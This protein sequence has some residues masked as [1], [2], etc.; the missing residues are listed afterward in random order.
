MGERRADLFVGEEAA[1]VDQ[2][3]GSES[4]ALGARRRLLDA[5]AVDHD[6]TR[7]IG[8]WVRG[9]GHGRVGEGV[10]EW[11]GVRGCQWAWLMARRG[12]AR[13]ARP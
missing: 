6:L 1:V 3:E 8:V 10:Q 11:G 12:L 4:L 2:L 5:P 9:R 7:G 13:G